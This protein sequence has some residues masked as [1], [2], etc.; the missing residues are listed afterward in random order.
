MSWAAPLF[1]FGLTAI[2]LPLWLH[3]LRMRNAEQRP[4]S[5]SM[6]LAAHEPRVNVRRRWRYLALLALRVLLL[7]ALAAAFAQPMWRRPAASVRSPAAL[8][9]I[10][11][12]TSLSMGA[13]RHFQ[14][15]REEARRLIDGLGAGQR[16]QLVTAAD[17]LTVV[18]ST[19]SAP[20]ADV[21]ALRAA[22]AQL[23]PGAGRLD[24]GMAMQ[25]L[26]ALLLRERGPVAVHFISDLQASGTPTRFADLLPLSTPQRPVLVTLHPVGED[27]AAPNWAVSAI[28]RRGADLIVTVRGFHTFARTLSVALQIN[29]RDAGVARQSVPAE[30]SAEFIFHQ[31]LLRLGDNR[32]VARLRDA[33]AL[34]ADNVRWAVIHNQPT[35]PVPLLT[36][37]ADGR[38]AKYL[39][40]ALSAADQGYA[41]SLQL[42]GSFDART[43]PRYRW[44][45]VDDLG[46]LDA[47]LAAALRAYVENGGAMFAALGERAASLT[48][49]PV[50]GDTVQGSAGDNAPLAVGQLQASHPLIAGLRGWESLEVSHLLQLTPQPDDQLLAA[51]S[52][53]MPLLLERHLA[54]GRVLLYTSDLN[55]DWNDLPVQPLFVGL[56]AQASRYLSG[57]GEIP[58]DQLVGASL[59]L[60]RDGGPA[61]QLIDPSGRTV[62][63]LA[64]TS[65]AL[66]V[67]LDQ[68]GFYQ[69][70]TPAGDSLV[71][72]NPDPLE[73]D[74]QP[75]SPEQLARWRAALAAGPTPSGSPQPASR[76]PGAAI[77]LAPTLLGL[78]VLLVLGE[79]VLGNHTLLRRPL[80]GGGS[81]HG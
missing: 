23:R 15:A 27:S 22:L 21:A 8:Q 5:S 36:A 60:G 69:I 11:M 44:V 81:S 74:L 12:D 38:A 78:L 79:S 68:T 75:M 3:R 39:A 20:T 26:D 30:G 55:D 14:H 58:T 53:G 59:A 46:A 2:A 72:V 13:G 1:L 71:A 61:G 9:L 19:G 40:T 43:L 35:E 4:F 52:N 64:D 28:R 65:H 77:P 80:A 76:Q 70:Y 67:R 50:L 18:T 31:P 47:P 32:V 29:D 6:L 16:A 25:G 49:L 56:L 57:R 51:A 17:T 54:R 73:S 7:A 45:I 37:A 34:D 24:Y 10:V 48:R 62:L 63:S 42:A 66:T 41:A 33:D